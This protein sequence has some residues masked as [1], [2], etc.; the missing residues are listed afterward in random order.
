MS[1]ELLLHAQGLNKQ[2]GAVVAA[3]DVNVRVKT[4]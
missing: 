4:R 3:Q 2:F 1:D